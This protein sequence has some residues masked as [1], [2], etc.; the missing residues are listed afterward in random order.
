MQREI[1]LGQASKFT[2]PNPLTVVC[3]ETPAGKTQI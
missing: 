1:S 2:S 3:T